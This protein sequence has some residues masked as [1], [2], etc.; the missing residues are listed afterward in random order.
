MMTL[1]KRPR[2][3]HLHVTRLRAAEAVAP[4]VLQ[5]VWAASQDAD[6]PASRPRDGWW[7]IADWASTIRPLTVNGEVIGLAAV[8]VADGD[9][10]AEGRLALLPDRCTSLPARSLVDAALGVARA[11][12]AERLRLVV[13]RA[14]TWASDAAREAGF[15][16]IRAT[17]VMLRP[18]SAGT[19]ASPSLGAVRVRPLLDGEE[20]ALLAAL[21]RAWSGTWGFAPIPPAALSSDLR[22]QHDGM[23]VASDATDDSR[24]VATVHAIFDPA[25]H[26]LDGGPY[27]WISNLT[28]DPD[29][30]GRGLGRLMLAHGIGNLRDRGAESVMLGV[31][32]GNDAAVG[33]YRS[34]GFEIVSTTDIWERSSRSL[35]WAR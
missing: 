14:A 17:H 10:V 23:L 35:E 19:M 24:I 9:D 5:A 25:G 20:P 26:N 2:A 15:E 30:R 13:P 6:D 34:S 33:L 7:S 8:E 16:A 29:W 21:N 11:G 3:S 12:G 28:T 18:S 1:D 22:G 32:G 4:S 31:D 27:A